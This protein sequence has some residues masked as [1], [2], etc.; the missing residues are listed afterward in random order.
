[1]LT[2]DTKVHIIILV[3]KNEARNSITN[4]HYYAGV[5]TSDASTELSA[6]CPEELTSSNMLV[7]AGACIAVNQ[8]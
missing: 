8:I 3:T 6:S 7:D 1:M 4:L 2:L 5:V